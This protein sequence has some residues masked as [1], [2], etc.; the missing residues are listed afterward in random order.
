V[1]FCAYFGDHG[2]CLG[3]KPNAEFYLEAVWTMVI[4][5]LRECVGCADG[6]VACRH[7]AFAEDVAGSFD[8]FRHP[9]LS[10]GTPLACLRAVWYLVNF[11]EEPDGGTVDVLCVC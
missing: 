11:D 9:S 8:D 5:H 3:I 10:R 4:G 7:K 2:A 6:A 1:G